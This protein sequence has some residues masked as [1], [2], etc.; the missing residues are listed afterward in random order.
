MMLQEMVLKPW[1][2]ELA[3][4][5]LGPSECFLKKNIIPWES[6]FYK[7]FSV[8]LLGNPV[9]AKFV[10]NVNLKIESKKWKYMLQAELRPLKFHML[11]S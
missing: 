6:L 8:T 1:L 5:L 7:S 3:V 11:K 2:G 9:Y 10:I 4:V